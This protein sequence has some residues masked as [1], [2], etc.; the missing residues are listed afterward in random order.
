MSHKILDSADVTAP[1]RESCRVCVVGSGAGGGVMAMELAEAGL[2]VILIEEGGYFRASDFNQREGEMFPLLYRDKGAQSTRDL[3]ITVLQGRCVGG[4]TTINECICFRTP[5]DV[6]AEWRD[7]YGI[8]GYSPDDLAPHFERVEQT[9]HVVP[10]REDEINENGRVVRAGLSSLGYHSATFHHNRVDCYQC[11]YCQLGCAFGSHQSVDITYVPR[12]LDA[13]ARLFTRAKVERILE[14][15]G[16]AAGVTGRFIDKA[17]DR[18]GHSFA[19]SADIVVLAAGPIHSPV[20]LIESG[21]D[22]GLPHTGRN[23]YLHPLVPVLARM[24]HRIDAYHGIPMCVYSDQ[25]K[26]DKEGRRGFKIESVFARPGIAATAA[27]GFGLDHQRVMKDYNYLAASYGQLWDTGSGSV[28]AKNGRPVIE[29]RLSDLDREK[30][31]RAIIEQ[32]KVFFAAGAEEVF[33]T[34][35]LVRSLKSPADLA[36]IESAPM[37]PNDLVMLSPHPQGTCR[38]GNHYATSVVNTRLEH[39]HV[40]GLYV[41]DASVL[42]TPVGV[43]PMISIMGVATKAA[44]GIL[45]RR[46]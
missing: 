3:S 43:N 5:P 19:I 15:N 26:H 9:M 23:L 21:L 11:G 31:R 29:Y 33:S 45:E 14:R 20:L 6:L 25:F 7:V 24:K 10:L 30:A 39:H 46:G 22:K 35:T 44:F 1:V 17:T 32:A 41:A 12:A 42:P 18:P 13:G 16:R 28:T 40:R 37:R 36:Q 27:P 34:H 38:M 2:D 8:E 4:T